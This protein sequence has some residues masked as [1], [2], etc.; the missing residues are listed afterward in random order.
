LSCLVLSCIIPLNP[1]YFSSTNNITIAMTTCIEIDD[2]DF[3][4]EKVEIF[5]NLTTRLEMNQRYILAGLNG[6]GK[7]TLLKIIGGK[8]L[9]DANKVHVLGKDPF[10]DTTL[11]NDVVFINNS[12]GTQTMAYSGYNMPL[13]SSLQV[14]EMMKALKEQNPER[15]AELLDILDINPEWR[16]NAVSEGQRKR[17]QL[18]LNLL[19]P[20]KVCLLDE[21]TVNLDLLVKDKFLNYL[22]KETEI[23]DCCIVYVTHI[24]DGLEEWATRLVYLHNNKEIETFEIAE[25]PSIYKFLLEKFKEEYDGS[26]EEIEEHGREVS[27]KNAGGYSHGVLGGMIDLK[28][29]K[30]A[31]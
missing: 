17:V 31:R 27:R 8:V 22:K 10:R 2:L 7:S 1:E 30:G 16:L 28:G 3:Q 26:V 21:I 14:K 18:Y 11:N 24:F 15:D 5:K 9:C 6:C 23:R 20:F 12:W 29:T 4:Y 25:I 19:R 13:Q